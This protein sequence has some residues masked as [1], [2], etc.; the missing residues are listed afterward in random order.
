MK[1]KVLTEVTWTV[2][3]IYKEDKFYEIAFLKF[4]AYNVP[5]KF[6]Y[7]ETWSRLSQIMADLLLSMTK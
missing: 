5:W 3:F 6:Q 4:F 7:T 1:E 2:E